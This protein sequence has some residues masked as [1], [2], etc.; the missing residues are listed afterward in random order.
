MLPSP[1]GLCFRV[2][3]AIV[4]QPLAALAFGSA[5]GLVI[6]FSQLSRSRLIRA[7]AGVYVEAVR[8]IP[9]LLII[10]FVYYGLGLYGFHFFDQLGSVVLAMSAYA[11]AYLSQVFRAGIQSVDRRIRDAGRSIGMTRPQLARH[12]VLPLMFAQA[13][14]A[15]TNS[16][17]SLFKDTSLGSAIAV[18][19]LTFATIVINQNTFRVFEAWTAAGALYL[20]TSA[21]IAWFL[22]RVERRARRWV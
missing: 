3:L 18:T 8:N 2:T 11:G 15:L 6:A 17:I 22:R 19:E 12:A 1:H 10:F 7:A 21:V 5:I 13:L 16:S 14:P 4:V 20:A 9:L